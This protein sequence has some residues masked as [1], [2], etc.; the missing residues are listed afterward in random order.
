M[1]AATESQACTAYTRFVLDVGATQD[2]FALQVAM[3]PCLIGYRDIA[4]RIEGEYGA[5]RERNGFWRW[6]D[7]YSGVDFGQAYREGRELLEK[8]AVKQS[9]GRIE[10]LV[11][12]FAKATKVSSGS[13]SA[14][15][16]GVTDGCAAGGGVLDYGLGEEIDIYDVRVDTS[17]EMLC[18]NWGPR[19]Q[20]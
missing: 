12:V 1:D 8:Y 9:A 17:I 14:F 3:A 18:L 6:V 7:S 16:W 15:L 20:K 13:S 4:V 2:F 10:E 11:E 5:G 19:L